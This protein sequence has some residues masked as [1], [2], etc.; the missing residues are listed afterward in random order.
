M[1]HAP[2][3]LCHAPHSR[4]SWPVSPLIQQ[5]SKPICPKAPPR[6]SNL[7]VGCGTNRIARYCSAVSLKEKIEGLLIQFA[8]YYLQLCFFHLKHVYGYN[9]ATRRPRARFQKPTPGGRA[10]VQ[11]TDSR[12]PMSC[13]GQHVRRRVPQ[14]RDPRLRLRSH[15]LQRKRGPALHWIP[16]APE[17][18][19]QP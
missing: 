12:V 14:L 18:A 6:C 4:Q 8:L 1:A 3:N 19:A 2:Y 17:A 16:S 9:A 11:G 5:K 15:S 10:A 13:R 7:S